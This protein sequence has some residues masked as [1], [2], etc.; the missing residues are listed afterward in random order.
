LL[1]QALVAKHLA[2]YAF[3]PGSSSVLVAVPATLCVYRKAASPGADAVRASISFAPGDSNSATEKLDAMVK[4]GARDVAGIGRRAVRIA[5][6]IE[7]WS[8][9]TD[10]V[11]ALPAN[12]PFAK[13]LD[14]TLT[15]CA[16]TQ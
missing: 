7:F 4:N 9:H 10:C 11:V 16:P 2:G 15:A 14:A 1:P 5:D 6:D 3:D 8:T 12:E 13:D